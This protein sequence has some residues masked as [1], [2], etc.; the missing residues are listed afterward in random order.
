MSYSQLRSIQT[1]A[2]NNSVS[3]AMLC[4]GNSVA[5]EAVAEQKLRLRITNAQ[6]N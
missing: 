4:C 3:I 5:T 6:V 2:L 1:T